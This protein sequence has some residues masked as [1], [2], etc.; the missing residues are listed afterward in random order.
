[1]S[2]APRDPLLPD[3]HPLP[4]TDSPCK[5]ISYT[6]IGGFTGALFGSLGA[7]VISPYSLESTALKVTIA[8][9]G[10]I[11]GLTAAGISYP[12]KRLCCKLI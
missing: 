12:I 6:I 3:Y 1:M 4:Q 11:L 10:T 5:I 7:F 9:T 2:A 8:A